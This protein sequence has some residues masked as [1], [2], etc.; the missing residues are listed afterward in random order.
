MI[1]MH[2]LSG[3]SVQG[4][5]RAVGSILFCA[6]LNMGYT[7]E[8]SFQQIEMQKCFVQKLLLSP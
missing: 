2:I 8:K 4:R 6:N 5:Q 1:K 7:N 3:Q